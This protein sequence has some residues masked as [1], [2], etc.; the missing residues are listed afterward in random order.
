VNTAFAR[1]AFKSRFMGLFDPSR[2]W[3]FL[4][5]ALLSIVGLLFFMV[6]LWLA[7]V[8]SAKPLGEAIKLNLSLP[9]V[10]ALGDNYSRVFVE[11]RVARAFLNSVLVT[12]SS[13]VILL[14]LGSMAAWAFARTKSRA[15]RGTYYLVIIGVLVPPALVPSLVLMRYLGIEGTHLALIIF[16]VAM[17]LPL[18]VFLLTGFVRGLPREFEDAAAVDGAGT[19][20][21]YY[22]VMLPMMRPILLTVLVILVIV[23]WN[24]AFIPFFLLHGQER[25]TL[26]LSLLGVTEGGSHLQIPWNLLFTH[27]VLVSFPLMLL[28]FIVQRH[29]VGGLTQGAIK[30]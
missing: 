11:G 21:T 19:V 15:L 5:Y 26:P 6:P 28:Y 3:T 12:G 10:W 4:R 13:A 25:A 16:T 24:D 23:I 7:L 18:V 20:Q 27:L 8:T 30:G 14:A 1:P 17:R 22:H 2:L 29:V 9:S